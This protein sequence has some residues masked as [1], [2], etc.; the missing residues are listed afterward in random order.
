MW[1][2]D[3][4]PGIKVEMEQDTANVNIAFFEG[5]VS[6]DHGLQG[7]RMIA[8][9]T[10]SEEDRQEIEIPLPKTTFHTFYYTFPSGLEIQEKRGLFGVF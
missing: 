4:P 7:L 6:D 9:P 10:N 8:F 1:L 2:R 3:E 5:T